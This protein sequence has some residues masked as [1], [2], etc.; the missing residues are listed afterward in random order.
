M[1]TN[2][3]GIAAL[4]ASG[5]ALAVLATAWAE[6]QAH[7]APVAQP[8]A[9]APAPRPEATDVHVVA[10]YG[11]VKDVL[12]KGDKVDR[13]AVTAS[14]KEIAKGHAEETKTDPATMETHIFEMFHAGIA[15][16]Q[17]HPEVMASAETFHTAI[18]AGQPE[19]AKAPEKTAAANPHGGG[20]TQTLQPGA[21]EWKKSP[22]IHQFYDLTKATFA[23]GAGKMNF[24]EYQAK[25]YDI[26]RAFGASTGGE[27]GAAMMLDHLKDIPKQMVGI[28]K[29]DPKVI[30][31]FDNFWVALSGPE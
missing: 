20:T 2:R 25:S 9:G 7:P 6:P 1:K 29:D 3:I 30:D 4:L 23:K 13:A 16:A 5:T 14:L 24:K 26:F 12:A 19:A 17:A 8:A 18:H 31:S 28:V 27:K 22:F 21:S 10:L 15:A 11:L